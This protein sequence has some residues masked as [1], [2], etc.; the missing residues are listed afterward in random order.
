MLTWIA[1]LLCAHAQ[2]DEPPP[3]VIPDL[4]EAE[5]LDERGMVWLSSVEDLDLAFLQTLVESH[6][7]VRQRH[8]QSEAA[9]L[10]AR[11]AKLTPVTSFGFG[12]GVDPFAE[13][14]SSLLAGSI[15]MRIDVVEIATYKLRAQQA[16][17]IYLSVEALEDQERRSLQSSLQRLYYS[18][19]SMEEEVLLRELRYQSFQTTAEVARRQFLASEIEL[20]D[21]VRIAELELKTDELLRSSRTELTA[22]R[23]E[24]ELVIGMSLEEALSLQNQLKERGELPR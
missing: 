1:L 2:D 23:A 5:N 12:F 4:S 21:V 9:R 3:L 20:N 6:P 16:Q 11:Q 18:I 22:L 14:D 8:H 10:A 15:G 19:L 24:L 7:N 17:E 13:P